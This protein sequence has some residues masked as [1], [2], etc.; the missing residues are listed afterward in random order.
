[1]P[2]IEETATGDGAL[3]ATVRQLSKDEMRKES[4]FAGFD[5]ETV[6]QMG[7]NHPVFA[8]RGY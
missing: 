4:S 7:E 1:M 3:F 6:W 2:D 8:Q 5:F